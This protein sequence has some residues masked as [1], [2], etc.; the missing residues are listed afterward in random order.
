LAPCAALGLV[1]LAWTARHR[2]FALFIVTCFVGV[3][4]ASILRVYPIGTGYKGRV[5]LFAY[6]L[7]PMLVAVGIG[8]LTRWLPARRVVQAAA[9][10]A[11]A[12][13]MSRIPPPVYPPL[14]LSRIA[15][16]L[17]ASAGPAD[18]IVLNTA[19]AGLVGYYTSWPVTARADRAPYRFVIVRPLTLTIP[20][21]SEDGGPGLEVLDR[22][23]A[24]VR[25]SRL[26]FMSTR[27]KTQH[28]ERAIQAN[29]FYE[30]RRM[31]SRISTQLIEYRRAGS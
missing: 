22:F 5:T 30:A 4:A 20:R 18:A 9:A 31:T 21:S 25:P 19:A 13:V 15:R 16:A 12:I 1:A 26:F 23:L 17:E 27:R 8:A 7:V 14:D 3:L 29:G 10:I 2:W 11:V 6:P 24:E 28:A